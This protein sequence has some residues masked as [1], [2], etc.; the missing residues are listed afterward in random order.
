MRNVLKVGLLS[1]FLMLLS[2]GCGAKTKTLTCNK[3]SDENDKTSMSQD[4]EV[5]FKDDKITDINQKIKMTIKDKYQAYVDVM[6]DSVRKRYDSLKDKEGIEFKVTVK[7]NVIDTVLN[8][9]LDQ[10]DEDAKKQLSIENISSKTYEETIKSL[11]D[12]GYNCK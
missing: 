3:T 12:S 9:K 5:I 1:M 4:V 8:A 7:D 11:E 2:T 10:I 6:A